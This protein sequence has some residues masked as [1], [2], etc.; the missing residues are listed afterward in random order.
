MT[1]DF[2]ALCAELVTALEPSVIA[3]DGYGPVAALLPKARTALAEPEP[4]PAD[5][6]VAE[7]VAWLL[8]KAVQAADAN[9]SR[10]AGMLTWAAQI[11]GEHALLAPQ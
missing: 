9:Q 8:D 7:L 6:E 5:G 3:R 2:R 4:Q 1:T 11:V 10:A